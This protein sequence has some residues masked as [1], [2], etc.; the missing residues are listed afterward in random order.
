MLGVCFELDL[1]HEKQNDGNRIQ[2]SSPD[3]GCSAL[4]LHYTNYVSRLCS[5]SLLSDGRVSTRTD[6]ALAVKVSMSYLHGKT[7]WR[8]YRE[9]QTPAPD[10]NDALRRRLQYL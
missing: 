8:T 1:L 3:D 10:P 2:C 9:G 6:H 4:L 5:K 7:H